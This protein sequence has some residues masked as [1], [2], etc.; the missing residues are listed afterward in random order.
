MNG[1]TF[2]EDEEEPMDKYQSPPSANGICSM[3]GDPVEDCICDEV[4]PQYQPM[5]D[6]DGAVDHTTPT[7]MA[8]MDQS[9]YYASKGWI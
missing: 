2:D 7:R 9:R 3:C 1:S 8:C 5:Q 6:E 4:L